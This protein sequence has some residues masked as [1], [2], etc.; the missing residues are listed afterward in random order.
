MW[1]NF[2]YEKDVETPEG[3]VHI[4]KVRQ[5]EWLITPEITPTAT[6]RLAFDI[7]YCPNFVIPSETNPY[8]ADMEVLASADDGETWEKIWCAS[9]AATQMAAEGLLSGS[10]VITGIGITIR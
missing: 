2:S 10:A 1:I 4:P 9:E 5:D 7:Y 6:S 8:D 3:T